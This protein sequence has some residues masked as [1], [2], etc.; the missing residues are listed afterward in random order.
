MTP[1]RM[2][3][4]TSICTETPSRRRLVVIAFLSRAR[5]L[6]AGHRGFGLS[7]VPTHRSYQ[8]VCAGVGSSPGTASGSRAGLDI[9]PSHSKKTTVPRATNTPIVAHAVG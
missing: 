2:A 8:S 3:T 7:F 6:L 4:P 1:S 5:A 9:A